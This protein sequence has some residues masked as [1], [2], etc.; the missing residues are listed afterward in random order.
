MST[1]DRLDQMFAAARREQAPRVDVVNR[2]ISQL[3]EPR[4]VVV[5]NIDMSEW[6]GAGAST[7]VAACCLWLVM[8]LWSSNPS[9]VATLSEWHPLAAMLQQLP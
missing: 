9:W 1:S 4:T 2:V 8:P 3:S 6:I 7:L 5:S